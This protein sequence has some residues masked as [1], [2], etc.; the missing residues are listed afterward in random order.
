MRQSLTER[1]A[2]A[3]RVE[4]VRRGMK[5]SELATRIDE[6][7]IWL[8]RRLTK[9]TPF[10]LEDVQRIADALDLPLTAL[11]GEDVAA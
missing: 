9:T 7:Y 4:M 5:T 8:Q 11:V 3:I 6:S 10:L 2:L 1:V